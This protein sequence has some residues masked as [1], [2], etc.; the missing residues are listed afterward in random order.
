MAISGKA[1]EENVSNRAARTIPALATAVGIAHWRYRTSRV[2]T[3]VGPGT[4]LT[5][6]RAARSD[7]TA[8]G[9]ESPGHEDPGRDRRWRHRRPRWR[10]RAA[11]ADRGSAPRARREPRRSRSGAATRPRTR[12][13]RSRPARPRAPRSPD[14]SASAVPASQ[15]ERPRP[16]HPVQRQALRESHEVRH[17]SIAALG[18]SL[19]LLLP[20]LC[21]GSK[22][23]F[24]ELAGYNRV[25]ERQR[26]H[27]RSSSKIKGDQSHEVPP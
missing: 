11:R 21:R 25:W 1:K 19:A 6:A 27:G 20:V 22:D 24:M 14:G 15:P 12:T 17:Q 2:A 16:S 9:H 18:C 23:A 4:V 10:H 3:S 26:C 5:T 7:P 13:G 8:C